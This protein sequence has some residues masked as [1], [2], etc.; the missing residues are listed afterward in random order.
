[1]DTDL[2]SN[3]TRSWAWSWSWVTMQSV[4]SRLCL[5]IVSQTILCRSSTSLKTHLTT[6]SCAASATC[7]SS[8]IHCTHHQH[9]PTKRPSLRFLFCFGFLSLW[10]W[11]ATLLLKTWGSLAARKEVSHTG[12]ALGWFRALTTYGSQWHGWLSLCFHSVQA[13]TSSGLSPQRKCLSGP[14][15]NTSSTVRTSA[16]ST[17]DAKLCSPCLSDSQNRLLPCF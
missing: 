10:T 2:I 7:T 3:S 15:R 4:N 5:C 14:S 17:P 12:G 11:C 1:M 16:I 6:G 9:G 13:L 8:C